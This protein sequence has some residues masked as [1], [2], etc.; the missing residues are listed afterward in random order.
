VLRAF[1]LS[2]REAEKGRTLSLRPA[3]L[4]EQVPREP[5]LHRETLSQK[6]K[7]KNIQ[8]LNNNKNNNNN[9]K[10]NK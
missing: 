9:N 2:T 3:Y 5:K 10:K 4:T 6:K 7:S 1:N 8:E